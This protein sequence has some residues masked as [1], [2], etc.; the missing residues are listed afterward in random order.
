MDVIVNNDLSSVNVNQPLAM[1]NF[2]RILYNNI[3]DSLSSSHKNIVLLCIGTDRSTGDSLG[4]LVGHRLNSSLN[5]KNVYT[6]GTLDNPVHAKNLAE[7]L[8]TINSLYESPFVIAVDA[9]LGRLERVGFINVGK[10]PLKPGAG[11]NKSLPA[12]GDIHIT[13]IVNL[14]GFMEYVIL[15]NTRLSLVMKMADTI[16]DGIKYS[17]WKLLKVNEWNLN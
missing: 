11:V 12:V 8:E 5:Y 9:C 16:A 17:M 13:G 1:T 7:N 6:Y 10:G 14:G 3:I 15:Q 2:S 4:P